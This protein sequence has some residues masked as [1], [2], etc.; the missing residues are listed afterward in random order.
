MHPHY[1]GIDEYGGSTDEVR[2]TMFVSGVGVPGGPSEVL[3][4]S[5]RL[6]GRA[7][8]FLYSIQPDVP[9][10]GIGLTASQLIAMALICF[11]WC[12]FS[13]SRSWQLLV[14]VATLSIGAFFWVYLQFTKTTCLLAIAGVSLIGTAILEEATSDQPRIGV[15][16][17]ACG[18]CC[19]ILAGML[20]WH[21]L[22][23]AGITLAPVAVLSGIWCWKRVA[24]WKHALTSAAIL[25]T[26]F[27]LYLWS[28]AQMRNDPEWAKF[29]DIEVPSSYLVNNRHASEW[30]SIQGEPSSEVKAKL[31]SV[32]WSH[33]DAKM[34]FY[35]LYFDETVFSAEATARASAAL[36]TI[37]ASPA[38]WLK[39]TCTVARHFI[40][41]PVCLVPL[42]FS[43]A[44]LA[45]ARRRVRLLGA[46]VW[47]GSCL[48]G[49]YLFLYLKLPSHVQFS[50]VWSSFFATLLL[51]AADRTIEGVK[52]P[53]F[54][55][56][57]GYPAL[58]CA[59][60]LAAYNLFDQ[61][62]MGRRGME[63]RA[64]F[65]AMVGDLPKGPDNL[66]LI[67][68]QYPFQRVS[69][70]D[71]M[72]DWKDWHFLYTDGDLRS[73]RYYKFLKEHGIDDLTSALYTDPRIRL[74]TTEDRI[75]AIVLF[76][77]EHRNVDVESVTIR[78][79]SIQTIFQLHEKPGLW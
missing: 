54:T 68:L 55:K 6:L 42:L 77:K 25:C 41:T 67:V 43:A 8:K 31:Q 39:A 53:V 5:N 28:A 60:A 10:V 63:R 22:L 72:Q 19:L 37:S 34:L 15:G 30:I 56:W 79:D 61:L 45:N 58:A 52:R 73:P 12:R 59:I 57:I 17:I 50:I 32:G 4:Y 49:A 16:R 70:F 44:V 33:N 66:Y 1:S 26:M 36:T 78:K 40:V 14:F 3:L 51:V 13:S 7:L 38:T 75:A 18:W 20:R 9:W 24:K 76:L 48:L 46:S 11:A 21:A 62:L 64:D 29:K 35:W 23:L 27:G 71:T 74:I 2:A 47:L 65:D 69:P